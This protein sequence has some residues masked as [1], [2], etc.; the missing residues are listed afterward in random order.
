MRSQ[1]ILEDPSPGFGQQLLQ[2]RDDIERFFGNL[3]NWGGGLHCLPPGARTHRRV[4]RWVQAKLII[5][6]VKRQNK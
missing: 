2:Q 3:T 1:A 5:N 4:H 6:A